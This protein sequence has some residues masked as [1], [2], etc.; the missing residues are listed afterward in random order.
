MSEMEALLGKFLINSNLRT[1]D[2]LLASP[3]MIP[4]NIL[5]A[6]DKVLQCGRQIIS[7][8]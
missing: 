8:L 4:A 6:I 1:C 3:D 2:D 7:K 5:F